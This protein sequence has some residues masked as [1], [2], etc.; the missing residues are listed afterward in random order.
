[1]AIINKSSLK[2]YFESGDIPTQA[3]YED[4]IESQFNLAETSTQIIQGVISAST[5]NFDV[6]QIKKVHLPGIGIGTASIGTSFS[7]GRTFEVIG[8]QNTTGTGS[9]SHL[10]VNDSYGDILTTSLTSSGNISASGDLYGTNLI[11]NEVEADLYRININP[12]L[13][14]KADVIRMEGNGITFGPDSDET[15]T[16][17]VSGS[18][19]R[20]YANA[21]IITD[22]GGNDFKIEKSGTE[23]FRFN[24]ESTPEIDVT[25]DL[26][27]DPS[28][29]DVTFSGANINVEGHITAS[30]NI[31]LS[32]TASFGFLDTQTLTFTNITSSGDILFNTGSV[33]IRSAGDMVFT[34]EDLGNLGN[35]T[36]FEVKSGVSDSTIFKVDDQGFAYLYGGI[37]F[38]EG[39]DQSLT[40]K[41]NM[42]F[43]LD[44]DDNETGQKF[45]FKNTTSTV[46]ATI[47]E[48][49]NVSGSGYVS[50]MYDIHATEAVDAGNGSG[51]P[52]A[53]SV[54]TGISF[55]STATSKSHVSLADGTIGQIKHIIHKALSNTV[56]LVITP[57]NFTAGSTMTSD[58]AGRGITLIF[59]GTNWNILGDV[60]EF[61]IA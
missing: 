45:F 6:I 8:D 28:G 51:S 3:Q 11:V 30:G 34:I 31:S 2:A 58:A 46:V 1:M 19:L 9:F 7:V 44:Y 52:T 36:N 17:T 35:T 61:V 22:T 56:S 4:L 26:I 53:L 24:L 23:F 12:A 38:G 27:I 50:S 20:L 10:I 55:V 14:L 13:D 18:T 37:I 48:S 54:S 25:G 57:T 60:G 41:G 39:S 49:G 43:I 47:D 32:G 5:A 42:T 21:D 15:Y 59:D 29:G 40:S 33:G 16:T